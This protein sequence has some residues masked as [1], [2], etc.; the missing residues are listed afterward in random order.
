[1]KKFLFGLVLVGGVGCMNIQPVGPMAKMMPPKPKPADP[2][3]PVLATPP[4]PVP[5]ASLIQPSDVT[6][7]NPHA[8]AQKLMSELDADRKTMTQTKTAEVS[9]IK[10]RVKVE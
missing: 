5:P 3:E 2:T 1:M 7:D 9:R 4:K 8:A 6:N 10:G